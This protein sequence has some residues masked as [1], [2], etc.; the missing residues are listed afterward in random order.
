MVGRIAV[1]L[2]VACAALA[3]AATGDK[4]KELRY[5]MSE[6]QVVEQLGPP[7][8]R[9]LLGGKETLLHT[10]RALSF[11]HDVLD[12]ADYPVTL[13]G[14]KVVAYGATDVRNNRRNGTVLLVPVR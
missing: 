11:W 7:D 12:R 5:G 1:F 6:S 2:L 4:V 8:G 9:G 10:N 13:V 3:C 14:C